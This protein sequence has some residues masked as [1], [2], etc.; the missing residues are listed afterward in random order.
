VWGGGEDV[1]GQFLKWIEKDSGRGH[2]FG[3]DLTGK[4][5][6]NFKI[7]KQEKIWIE[8]THLYQLVNWTIIVFAIHAINYA[9]L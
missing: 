4:W 5:A 3:L 1:T 8:G 2:F 9:F 7:V 6:V